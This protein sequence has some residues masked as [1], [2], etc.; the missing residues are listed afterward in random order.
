MVTTVQSSHLVAG[1]LGGLLVIVSRVHVGPQDAEHFA[2]PLRRVYDDVDV[3]EIPPP[4]GDIVVW[5]LCIGLDERILGDEAGFVIII[6]VDDHEMA[7]P[8]VIRRVMTLFDDHRETGGDEALYQ[9]DVA[10]HT[11][12]RF[13][14]GLRLDE[15]HHL[16][17]HD[18]LVVHVQVRAQVST[19]IALVTL[20]APIGERHRQVCRA[21]VIEGLVLV[22]DAFQYHFFRDRRG[23]EG[24]CQ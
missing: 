20:P 18:V 5:Q 13:E 14:V 22:A 24:W 11:A 12:Y 17:R 2:L 23:R 8:P 16:F 1:V 21:A 15:A 10:A 7:H 4:G 9:I 6:A 3:I 19:R